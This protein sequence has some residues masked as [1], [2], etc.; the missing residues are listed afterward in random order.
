MCLLRV[1]VG[2]ASPQEE[3]GV[4]EGHVVYPLPL[5]AQDL[6]QR[7]EGF[8]TISEFPSPGG[9]TQNIWGLSSWLFSSLEGI[10]LEA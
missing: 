10:V 2:L 5:S 9:H 4:L 8:P 6:V 7:L 1:L 3:V